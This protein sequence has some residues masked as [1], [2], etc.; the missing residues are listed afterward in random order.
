MTHRSL[1]TGGVALPAEPHGEAEGV[2]GRR[3]CE[4]LYGF[5]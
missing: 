2:R 3:E 4:P 5:P 1:E